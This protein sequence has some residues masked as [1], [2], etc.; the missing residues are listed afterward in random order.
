MKWVFWV[1]HPNQRQTASSLLRWKA[2]HSALEANCTEM[3]ANRQTQPKRSA[4]QKFHFANKQPNSSKFP[5]P[6]SSAETEKVSASCCAGPGMMWHYLRNRHWNEMKRVLIQ[7]WDLA[8]E[9][10]THS[11]NATGDASPNQ[12]WSAWTSKRSKE[13]KWS[14]SLIRDL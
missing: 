6:Q 11:L 1:P 8:Q 7:A 3:Q 14:P 5:W 9:N 4:Q 10:E 13:M 12:N 2:E